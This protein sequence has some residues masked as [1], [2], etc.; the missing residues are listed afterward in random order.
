MDY[1]S[2]SG[3]TTLT[4]NYTSTTGENSSDLDYQDTT[5]LVLNGGSITDSFGNVANLILPLPGSAG[6]LGANKAIIIDGGAPIVYTITSTVADGTYN[7]GD[8]IPITITF[9]DAITVTGYLI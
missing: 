6:S 3:T 9:S 4:F 7:L 8:I 2:G 5:A 1:V